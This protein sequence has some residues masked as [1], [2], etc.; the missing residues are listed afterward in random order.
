MFQFCVEFTGI[1]SLPRMLLMPRED[2]TGDGGE[3][4]LCQGETEGIVLTN[5]T[6]IYDYD[7]LENEVTS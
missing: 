3:T 7:Y 1:A 2:R 6:V 4:L 5:P